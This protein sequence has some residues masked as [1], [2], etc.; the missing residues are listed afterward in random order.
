LRLYQFDFPGWRV[1][2][3]GR[4]AETELAH[5]E[6]FIVVLV[7]EGEHVVEVLFGNTPVRTVAWSLT[8]LSLGLAL[9]IAKDLIARRKNDQLK[10]IIPSDG[11]FETIKKDW[12]IAVVVGGFSVLVILLEPLGLF[13]YES[14]GRDLDILTVAHFANFG[15]QIALLG[16]DSITEE[17]DAGSV[18]DLTLFWQALRPLEVDYQVF[19]HLLDG[20]GNLVAQSDKL[21]PGE[22]PTRRW[23]AERYVP[24]P[25]R[26]LLSPNTP[27]GLY[28]VA[29]GLWVQAEG[30]RLPLFND[31]GEQ[32]GDYEPLFKVEV[33]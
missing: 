21:N 17:I 6:G 12:P 15:D 5:P 23:P 27:P 18:I 22:F 13:H 32:V 28:T 3:D 33:K 24:D 16:F 31:S 10:K 25:H 1:T 4:P 8:L 7:P 29:A 20:D 19:V 2:V 26:L 11:Y 14:K 30:W 9:W